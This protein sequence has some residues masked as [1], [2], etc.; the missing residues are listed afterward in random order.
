MVNHETTGTGGSVAPGSMTN[1]VTV[2]K[3]VVVRSVTGPDVTIIEGARTPVSTNG[4][5][6]RCVWLGDG[7]MLSGFTLT[8]GSTQSTGGANASGG[9]A[10]CNSTAAILTD[11]IISGNT[12]YLNGGGVFQGTLQSCVISSNAAVAGG[13]AYNAWLSDSRVTGNRANAAPSGLRPAL[14]SC[15][16]AL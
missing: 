11:C 6:S 7:A 13:G 9:G 8:N 2:A 3:A 1:R 14:P 16:T 15:E 4:A 12:A 5:M 10:W